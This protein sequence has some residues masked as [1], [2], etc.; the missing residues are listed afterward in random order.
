MAIKSK[1]ACTNPEC[2]HNGKLQP[3]KN[4]YSNVT[5]PDGRVSRCRDCMYREQ[6]K[7]CEENK[8]PLHHDRGPFPTPFDHTRELALEAAKREGDFDVIEKLEYFYRNIDEN[9]MKAWMIQ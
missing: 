1:K 9:K 5:R 3:L 8:K 2:E 4:F 7:V 6:Q